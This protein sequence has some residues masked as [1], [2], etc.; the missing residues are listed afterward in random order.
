MNK[1]YEH[2]QKIERLARAL[3]SDEVFRW[4]LEKGL[5]PEAYVLPPCFFIKAA[6]PYASASATYKYKRNTTWC[7]PLP[8]GFPKTTYTDRR[9]SIVNADIYHDI[10]IELASHWEQVCDILFNPDNLITSYSF[11]LPVM[12]NAVGSLNGPR[13]GRMIYEWIAMAENDLVVEAHKY[14]YIGRTDIKNF[15]PSVYTHSIAWAIHGK[16]ESRKKENR[17]NHEL[18]GNRLDNLFRCM[19]DGRTNGIPVGPAIS[20]LI[21]EIVLTAVGLDC[22]KRLHD[23]GLANKVLLVRFKDDYRILAKK[24]SDGQTALKALQAALSEFNLEMHDGKTDFARLPQGLFRPWKS[25]YHSAKPKPQKTYNFTRFRELY[26]S[27]IEIER[28]HPGTGVIDRFLSDLINKRDYSLRLQLTPNEAERAVSLLLLL[29]EHRSKSFPM[30]LGILAELGKGKTKQ[31]KAIKQIIEDLLHDRLNELKKSE[32]DNAY[33]L[34]WLTYFLRAYGSATGLS[35]V[36][37]TNPIVKA[38]ANGRSHAHPKFNPFRTYQPVKEAK[39]RISLLEHLD[40]F[41]HDE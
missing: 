33:Q 27:V 28:D 11:P 23:K 39:M 40:V 35:K 37:W 4:L 41:R 17:E 12:T 13:S 5:Y 16:Q 2:G 29:S 21:A 26:L 34:V 20:D 36:K 3:P 15:Y 9:F 31:A 8:I 24:Q 14:T 19:N 1:I 32:D 30:I 6:P 38:V 7:E 18:I 25:K 10:A 22:S